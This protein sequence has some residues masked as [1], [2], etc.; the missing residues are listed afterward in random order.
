MSITFSPS[1][2]LH[3]A[4]YNF[5]SALSGTLFRPTA[6]EVAASQ[7][8]M[9]QLYPISEPSESIQGVGLHFTVHDLFDGEFAVHVARTDQGCIDRYPNAADRNQ[10]ASDYAHARLQQLRQ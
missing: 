9:R 10:C 5:W 2:R 8:H 4:Y 7:R 3:V 1:A 6:A